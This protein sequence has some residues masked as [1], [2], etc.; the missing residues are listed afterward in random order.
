MTTFNRRNFLKTSIIG[1]VAATFI[2]PSES[3]AAPVFQDKLSAPARVSLTTGTS[4]ADMA[5]RAL[6]PFSSQIAQAVGKKRIVLKPNNV[7]RRTV[8]AR[9]L[10]SE[11]LEDLLEA[12]DVISRLAEMRFECRAQ[13]RR[14][15]C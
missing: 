12:A 6:K 3:F 1:G 5:F 4:R 8:Y 11:H 10:R 14:S 13:L 9:G 15:P 2:R 7:D